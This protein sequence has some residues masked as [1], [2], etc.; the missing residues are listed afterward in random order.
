MSLLNIDFSLFSLFYLYKTKTNKTEI[1][2]LVA[3]HLKTSKMLLFKL[4]AFLL[5]FGFVNLSKFPNCTISYRFAKV[6][7]FYKFNDS[8][9]P[10]NT[11]SCEKRVVRNEFKCPTYK[12]VSYTN[13]QN[14]NI[15]EFLLKPTWEV[16][17]KISIFIE[18]I[19]RYQV[20]KSFL[21]AKLFGIK[22][23]KSLQY[24]TFEKNVIF[25]NLNEW[26]S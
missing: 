26:H 4:F 25:C 13:R 17:T 3:F 21:S 12:C 16:I 8:C 11:K 2:K 19:F 9:T 14:R 10:W 15:L 7:N 5:L 6:C 1:S 20:L 23:Q 22:S 18:L 24:L